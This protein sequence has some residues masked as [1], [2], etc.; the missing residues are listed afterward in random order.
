MAQEK[1]RPASSAETLLE[2]RVKV[3]QP[4]CLPR[5]VVQKDDGDCDRLAA[6]DH[7][8]TIDEVG[9]VLG[10]NKKTLERIARAG[11]I[12][13]FKLVIRFAL[14]PLILRS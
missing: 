1:M 4:G 6:F 13:L 14:I 8:L 7:A 2:E 9:D 10:F 11:R 3:F 12:P 5:R